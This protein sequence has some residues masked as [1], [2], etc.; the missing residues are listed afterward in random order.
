[1]SLGTCK[2]CGASLA[3]YR[4]HDQDSEGRLLDA[5]GQPVRV[6]EGGGTSAPVPTRWVVGCC[7]CMLRAPDHP[8]QRE[9]DVLEQEHRKQAGKPAPAP[10]SIYA[11]QGVKPSRLLEERLQALAGRLPATCP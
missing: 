3:T 8:Y 7:E 11:P 9:L 10:Q 6:F 5:K 4:T 2:G 1:M